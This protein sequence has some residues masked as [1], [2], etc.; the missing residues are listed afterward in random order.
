MKQLSPS[1]V[2]AVVLP[3]ADQTRGPQWPHRGHTVPH[4]GCSERTT[5]LKKE[6][7]DRHV[8]AQERRPEVPLPGP[9]SRKWPVDVVGHVLLTVEAGWHVRGLPYTV[10][11]C[12]LEKLRVNSVKT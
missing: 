3:E 1:P 9:G 6:Q 8:L 5:S 7:P 4:R 12:V 2:R 10:L 11:G